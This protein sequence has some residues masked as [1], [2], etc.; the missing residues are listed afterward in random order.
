MTGHPTVSE[1]EVLAQAFAYRPEWWRRYIHDPWWPDLLDRLPE[2]P[3]RP[4]YLTISRRDVFSLAADTTPEGRVRLLV[5]AYVWGTG[6]SA[7][8]VGRRARTFT[9]SNL[10]ETAAK[11]GAVTDLMHIDG[12]VAAYDSLLAR[13]PNH[14]KFMGPAFF[15]KYLYFAA[16]HPTTV[17]P[18]PL[19]LDKFVALS[20]NKHYGW[21]LPTTGW[22]ASTYDRYLNH[23][24]E[25]AAAVG[26]GA[27]P[28][29]IEMGWYQ[30]RDRAQE[31]N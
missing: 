27:T 7:F 16:G 9:R 2:D 6:S 4:G 1:T 25:K 14:I 10:T 22:S 18:Q 3:E 11:L 5:A 26:D 29:G 31:V 23:A 30:N 20:L 12:P 15:T 8:L 17:R 13:Q 21:C 19:I 28:A 24:A